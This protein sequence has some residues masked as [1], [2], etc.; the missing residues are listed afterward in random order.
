MSHPGCTK[1]A[2]ICLPTVIVLPFIRVVGW[3][4]SYSTNCQRLHSYK[5]RRSPIIPYCNSC[6]SDTLASGQWSCNCSLVPDVIRCIDLRSGGS[7]YQ[8]QRTSEGWMDWTFEPEL[9]ILVVMGV[10]ELASSVKCFECIY[11]IEVSWWEYQCLSLGPA[12]S[13]IY[14][15]N[16]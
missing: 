13:S 3:G 2:V 9:P 4:M 14:A 6:E 16:R 11:F 15:G 5:S 10:N 12:S 8:L 1:S 7:Q